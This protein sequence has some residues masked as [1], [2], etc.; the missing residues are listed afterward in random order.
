M[1]RGRGE[2]AAI[3]R[4]YRRERDAKTLRRAERRTRD[5]GDAWACPRPDKR[6]HVTRESA[7]RH[8]EQVS[9]PTDTTRRAVYECTCGGGWV[10]GRL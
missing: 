6:H 5:A 2:R 7:T 4:Q 1:S 9:S 8:L 3:T 10:W